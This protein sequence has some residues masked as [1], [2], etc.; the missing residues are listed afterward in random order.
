MIQ[1]IQSLF[2]LCVLFACIAC[3]FLPFW[4]FA[5]PDC[6]YQVN[7]LSVKLISGNCQNLIVG[8]IPLIVLVSI[9][10]ILSVISIFY[11]KNRL[12]QIRLNN[13]NLLFTLIFIATIYF[14]I[15]YMIE[16]QSPNLNDIWQFGLILPLFSLIFLILA[17]RFIKKDEKLVRSADRLR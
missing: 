8:T 16:E 15:P 9:S 17:N 1:R 12:L 10:S 7:L 4:I 5:G 6:A 13:F 11:Y 14:L 2:L 3:F